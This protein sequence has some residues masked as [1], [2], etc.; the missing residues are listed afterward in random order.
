MAGD[1]VQIVVGKIVPLLFD[2]AFC[3]SFFNSIPI[4]Y[5]TAYVI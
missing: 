2:F 4:H 1:S 5:I 3:L